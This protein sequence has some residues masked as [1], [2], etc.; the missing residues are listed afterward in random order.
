MR[1]VQVVAGTPVS[2]VD[3]KV[4]VCMIAGVYGTE[5]PA[6]VFCWTVCPDVVA[7]TYRHGMRN[8]TRFRHFSREVQLTSLMRTPIRL[9]CIHKTDPVEIHNSA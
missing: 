6:Y 7:S 5:W 8:L 1:R 3:N 2:W 9:L 4:E